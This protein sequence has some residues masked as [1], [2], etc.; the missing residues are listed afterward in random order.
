[1][2]PWLK[3][4]NIKASPIAQGA[5]FLS[6]SL[7]T[8]KSSFPPQMRSN[9]AVSG[10]A[11]DTMAL[12]ILDPVQ[13]PVILNQLDSESSMNI[14]AIRTRI[15]EVLFS[16]RG[17]AQLGKFDAVP[18]T[19][20]ETISAVYLIPPAPRYALF[21]FLLRLLPFGL[22]AVLGRA[23]YHIIQ[24]EHEHEEL[25]LKSVSYFLGLWFRSPAWNTTAFERLIT[26]A[27][28]TRSDLASLITSHVNYVPTAD[29]TVTKETL[30]HII[31]VLY[32]VCD[33]SED[34]TGPCDF[35]FR[36]VLLSHGIVTA[37]TTISQA[38]TE[39]LRAGFLP[40]LFTCGTAQYIEGS[41][42]AWIDLL[43]DI[44]P[45]STVYYSV[46]SQ[47][48][49]SLAEVRDWDAAAIL[50]DTDLLELWNAL[51]ELLESQ[52]QIMD[53]YDMARRE[54][55]AIEYLL[56]MRENPTI[57]F[58]YTEGS[59]EISV[60]VLEFE[61]DA[62]RAVATNG[63]MQLRLMDVVDGDE[64]TATWCFPFPVS[65]EFLRGLKMIA[66]A[67]VCPEELDFEKIEEKVRELLDE[68]DTD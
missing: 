32:F 53:Q 9:A 20:T 16:L 39:A 45:A 33:P 41:C 50:A 37:L 65:A 35:A 56:F 58:D 43:R 63:R 54:E 23:W 12:G 68:F 26:G 11:E 7:N 48:R 19:N 36:D 42:D 64:D 10:S 25:G 60:G 8:N 18:S 34:G 27:W 47:F 61:Y 4:S 28:S 13:I 6:F 38:I 21:V 62:M 14:Y 66:D 1:M 49:I 46:H 15:V 40:A 24:A 52:F 30:Y 29:S 2:H 57:F 3:P 31:G 51:L 5:F 55:I 59:C 17:I 67:L 22:W 44:L